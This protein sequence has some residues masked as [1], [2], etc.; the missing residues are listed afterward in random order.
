M[1]RRDHPAT[2]EKGAEESQRKGEDHQRHVPHLQHGLLFL[3]H[4]RMQVGGGSKPGHDRRV[5]Y[6]VPGPV[7]AQAQDFIRPATTQEV[8][9]GQKEPRGQSPAPRGADPHVP[10]LAGGQGGDSKGERHRS[11]DIS[12]VQ[13]GRMDRHPVVLQER[14]QI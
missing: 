2:G 13:A 8:A 1:D 4:H 12:Q 3:D 6:R 11:A 5:F 9:H 10:Q 7:P 14:V